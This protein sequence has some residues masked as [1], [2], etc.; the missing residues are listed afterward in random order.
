[1]EVGVNNTFDI[2]YTS[3]RVEEG[4]IVREQSCQT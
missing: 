3:G 1:M 2:V 4:A